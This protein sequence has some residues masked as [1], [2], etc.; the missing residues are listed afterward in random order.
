[1]TNETKTSIKLRRK[2]IQCGKEM[3][4]E[5]DFDLWQTLEG[6]ST[7]CNDCSKK[8]FGND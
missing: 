4:N 1:M 2:C 8:E 7:W 3:Y 5:E 6:I